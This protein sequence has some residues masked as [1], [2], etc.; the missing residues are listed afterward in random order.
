MQFMGEGVQ[1]LA[2][3]IVILTFGT[4]LATSQ[5]SWAMLPGSAQTRMILGV[6]GVRLPAWE[7]RNPASNPY[8]LWGL[9]TEPDPAVRKIF[10]PISGE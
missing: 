1:G 3:L 8:A 9:K 7:Y 2:L 4:M 10:Q 6:H 5:T